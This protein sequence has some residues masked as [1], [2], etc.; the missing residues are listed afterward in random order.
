MKHQYKGYTYTPWE[1]REEDCVKIWHDIIKP[2]GV[3][4]AADFTPYAYMNEQAFRLWIDLGQPERISSAPLDERDLNFLV[5]EFIKKSKL[6]L[7]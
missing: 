7:I 5:A 2:N 6:D 3:T 4:V 1:D